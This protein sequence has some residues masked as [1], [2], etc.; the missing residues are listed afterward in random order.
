MKLGTI[1]KTKL[2][3]KPIS[4]SFNRLSE[5]DIDSILLIESQSSKN[6]WTKKQLLDSIKNPINLG[7]TLIYKAEIIGFL[8]AMPVIESADILNIAID[9]RHQRKGY[10]KA[11]IEHLTQVLSKR[12]I[13]AVLL[14]VRES[15]ISAI[16]F[17]LAIG[18]KEISVQKSY[19]AKNSNQP[20]STEDGIMMRL[21]I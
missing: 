14:E 20:S 12:G 1:I 18:F 15:N 13:A 9:P 21:E 19:Y 3:T 5:K 11:L 16:E 2:T 7:Y 17:Y 6:P 10:G 4:I 8:L